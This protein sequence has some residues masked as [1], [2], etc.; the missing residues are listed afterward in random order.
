MIETLNIFGHCISYDEINNAETS[1]AE[2]QIHNQANQS[3][4]P[5]NVQPSCFVTFVYDNCE[6]NPETLF[7]FALHCKNGIT[8]H[9]PSKNR[10]ISGRQDIQLSQQINQNGASRAKTN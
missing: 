4:V 7:G 9:L 2:L 8:I 1:F 5:N 6:H 3:F 10:L